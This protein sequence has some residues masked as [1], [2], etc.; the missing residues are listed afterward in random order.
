MPR[1]ILLAEDGLVNQK[2]VV[3]LLTKR[4]HHVTI[5]GNGQE[6]VEAVAQGA[7]DLVL[8]DVQ[9]PVMDG[10]A[11]TSVIRQWERDTGRSLA[12][13]AMTAHAMQGDRQRCLDA[14][15][16][17]YVSKPFRPQELFAAVEGIKPAADAPDCAATESANAPTTLPPFNRETALA[18]VGGSEELFQEI[19]ELFTRE[20]PKQIDAMRQA[21]MTGN[22]ADLARIAHTLKGAISHFEAQSAWEA[23]LRIETMARDGRL[24]DYEA[25]WSSLKQEIARLQ[26]ALAQGLHVSV[27]SARD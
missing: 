16:D 27:N 22:N 20:C 14:G 4:G 18:N 13:I 19:V 6:A 17:G 21:R 11:A 2:V 9:M 3:S 8:M 7:F 23:A 12:I 15:M 24:D 26:A 25:A 1:R 10:F 5:V